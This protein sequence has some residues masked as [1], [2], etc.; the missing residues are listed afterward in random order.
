MFSDKPHCIYHKNQIAEVICQLRFPEILTIGANAPV[1]FQ[2][3]IRGEFPR[4]LVQQ[5]MPAPKISGAPGNLHLE[6][7]QPTVN[8]QFITQDG[9]WRINLTSR[10]ISLT[11]TRYVDW[12]TFANMLDAPLAAFIKIYKPAYFERIGLRYMN[13]FSRAELVLEGSSFRELFQPEYLGLL[14]YE[15]VSEQSSSRSGV[16]AELAIPGGCRVKI[17]AGPGIVKRNGQTDKEIKFILDIDLFMNGNIPINYSAGALQTLHNQA[18]PIF[19]GAITDT[20]HS[21]MEPI[22]D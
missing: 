19:R 12:D 10:F 13:F 1:D 21:A 9:Q 17:H 8:Y 4:Y 14:A 16:D 22:I 3:A 2:E 20:L 5:E 18:F 15:N 6:N 7:Q 11:C